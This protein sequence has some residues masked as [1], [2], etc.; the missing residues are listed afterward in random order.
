MTIGALLKEKRLAADKTQK[1]W[2]GTIISPSYY[3]K[4][5]K[6]TTELRRQIF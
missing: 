2:V 4:V 1:E 5:E 3:A 6:I